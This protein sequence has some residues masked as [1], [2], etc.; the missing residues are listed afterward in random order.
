[1]KLEKIALI[2]NN[3]RL[4]RFFE[5]E[6]TLLPYELYIFS[7]ITMLDAKYD[8]I[9]IDS[10]TVKDIAN[11][12]VCPVIT[13][14][15][16]F[17]STDI[18]PQSRTCTLPWPMSICEIGKVLHAIEHDIFDE[19]TE[20]NN[21]GRDYN[22]VSV[23]DRG[24]NS[25]I[26]ENLHLRLTPSEFAVLEVLCASSGKLVERGR[27][28]ELLGAPDSNIVDVYI[29]RLRKKLEAP[30]NRKLIYA[31]RGRGYRTILKIKK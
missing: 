16:R 20:E 7:S 26:V 29:C 4:A 13:V 31:E 18:F 17:E 21:S 30:L 25:I 14:S 24:T 5:L 1:M 27:I 6:L 22:T 28:S 11:G 10:D 23:V 12:S 9:V 8:C 3:D 19:S 15:S 2:T